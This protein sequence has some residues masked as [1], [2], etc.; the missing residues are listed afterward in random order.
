MG[1]PNSVTVSENS[2]EIRGDAEDTATLAEV[3]FLLAS[4]LTFCLFV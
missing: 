2:M 1:V 3:L 4:V